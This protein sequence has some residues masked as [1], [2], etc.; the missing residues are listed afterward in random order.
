MNPTIM[1][2]RVSDQRLQLVNE[3][4]IASG[5]VDVVQIRFEFCGLWTGC[6]KTAVFYRNKDEVYHVPIAVNL[7]TV[8]WE[9]LADEGYFYFGVFGVA[10]N[11]RPTEVVKIKVTQGAIT[12]AT[13]EPKEP[14]PDIYEQLVSGYGLLESRFDNIIAGHSSGGISSFELIGATVSGTLT[15]NGSVAFANITLHNLT[16]EPGGVYCTDFC[17]PKEWSPLA[18]AIPLNT[19][20]NDVVVYLAQGPE[21]SAYFVVQALDGGGITTP[22]T[23][24]IEDSYP[25]R[26]P[27]NAELADIRVGYDGTVHATAGEAVRE[28][29]RYAAQNGGGGGGG[30]SEELGDISAALDVILAMQRELMGGDINAGTDITGQLV[31]GLYGEDY[32]LLETGYH[33]SVT[34][35]LAPGEYVL[36]FDR[37]VSIARAGINGQLDWAG[38]VCTEYPFTVTLE[39]ATTYFSFALYNG[40]DITTW[41]DSTTILLAGG[42]A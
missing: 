7:V 13:A 8:P 6:G 37:E 1:T 39:G 14:T 4:L 19:T 38:L 35:N 40:P 42:D 18:Q 12:T 11:V 32:A 20:S 22:V 5:G 26:Y 41:D 9:V 17:I 15:G 31:D 36:R 10:S 28:Q 29:I 24:N 33:K 21:D 3:P 25:L 34:L 27:F 2:A 23:I 16:W 30:S